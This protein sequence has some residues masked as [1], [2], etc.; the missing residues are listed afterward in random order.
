MEE[1]AKVNDPDPEFVLHSEPLTVVKDNFT[2][3][4]I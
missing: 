3:L 1:R 4:V 2:S